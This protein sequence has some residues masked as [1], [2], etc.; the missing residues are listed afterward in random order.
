ML[1]VLASTASAASTDVCI[2]A[3]Q[4][5]CWVTTHWGAVE[6]FDQQTRAAAWQSPLAPVSN[7]VACRSL[8]LGD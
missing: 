4:T 3:M 1:Q 8:L 2:Q 7:T 6:E 5:M